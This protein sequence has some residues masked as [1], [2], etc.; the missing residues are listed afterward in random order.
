MVQCHKY[1]AHMLLLTGVN[2]IY[3]IIYMYMVTKLDTTIYNLHTQGAGG[4][5]DVFNHHRAFVF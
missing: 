5:F 2:K 4:V 3:N 1:T